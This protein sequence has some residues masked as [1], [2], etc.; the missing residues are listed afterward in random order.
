MRD[1]EREAWMGDVAGWGGREGAMAE[2][3]SMK[4]IWRGSQG[5]IE[6]AAPQQPATL[7]HEEPMGHKPTAQHGRH[8]PITGDRHEP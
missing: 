5:H 1:N 2:W 4:G 6:V 8:D 7:Q 3:R